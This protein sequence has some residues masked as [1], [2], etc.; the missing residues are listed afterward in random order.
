MEKIRIFTHVC[1]YLTYVHK[2][3]D[4]THVYILDTILTYESKAHHTHT[5]A[6]AKI[7]LFIN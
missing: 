6:S 5:Y 1:K 7:Q 4:I 2:Y 3:E